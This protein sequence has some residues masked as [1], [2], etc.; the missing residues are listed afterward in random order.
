[1][2]ILPTVLSLT[3]LSI[4][5]LA[6]YA[7]ISSPIEPAAYSPPPAPE[8]AGQLTPNQ[9]LTRAELLATGQIQ[10]PEDVDED[11]Q[12]RVYAGLEDGRVIRLSDDHLETFADT[13][14]RPLGLAFD[15]AGNLIV[16][17]AVKG[18]LSIA[19]DGTLTQ[20]LTEVD[21]V[22]FGFTDD[23]DVGR[24]GTIYFSDASYKW[25]V[26]DFKKDVIE[27]RP[28]G[29]LIRCDPAS[30]RAETLLKDLYFANGVALSAD[31][32]FVL[33]NE[34]WAY[35]VVRYW[36]KGERAGQTDIFIDNLPGFPDGISRGR[37]PE[38]GEPVFWLALF[39]PR[40]SLLD[41]AHPYPWVK[42]ILMALPEF[43]Q[44]K[45]VRYG[46]VLALDARGKILTSLHDPNGQHLHE[47]TSV[48]QV[49]DRLYLGSL[50]NDRIGRLS[51]RTA[52]TP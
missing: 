34:T 10:G 42:K 18:L 37:H 2:R 32:D 17:D 39:S 50:H 11:A 12:G 45:P 46:L 29:R 16:A 20:L 40:N 15:P 14:G 38:T 3:I 28:H 27:M 31:E 7:L 6:T 35:R 41:A 26:E 44:P 5:T 4:G 9:A 36:L 19:P 21:G 52:L 25:G 13:G 48:Q 8:L 51:V 22:P 30:G 43:L 33:V 49:G 47:V 1:M 24:D 23:V